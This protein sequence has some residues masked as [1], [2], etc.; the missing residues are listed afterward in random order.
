MAKSGASAENVTSKEEEDLLE[1]SKRRFKDEDDMDTSQ[2]EDVH[3]KP[4]T[5]K[6]ERRSYWDSILGYGK[7]KNIRG[8]EIDD[9]DVFDD[10]LIEESTDG[11]G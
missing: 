1:R 11:T 6:V 4:T 9:R 5:E 7:R 3:S 2:P 10:D 8:E